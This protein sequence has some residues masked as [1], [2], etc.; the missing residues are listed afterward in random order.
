MRYAMTV[1]GSRAA[2]SGDEDEE[3]T[4]EHDTDYEGFGMDE[5][6]H[7]D[8][9]HTHQTDR[10]PFY[11]N[12]LVMWTDNSGNDHPTGIPAGQPGESDNARTIEDT[13]R[14]VSQ[15]RSRAT[16][17]DE[18]WVDLSYEGDATLWGEHGTESHPYDTVLEG[19]LAVSP[20]GTLIFKP[21]VELGRFGFS[22]KIKKIRV[23]GETADNPDNEG[24]NT[25]NLG[26]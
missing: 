12:P 5:E 3:H 1:M 13:A 26:G 7:A 23:N 2:F 10:I 22:K 24:D 6:D 19:V 18:V 11:S 17:S 25:G 21:G 16:L 4:D 14:F 8:S 20:T 15:F 9:G